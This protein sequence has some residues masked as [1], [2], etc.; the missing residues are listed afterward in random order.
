MSDWQLMRQSLEDEGRWLARLRL[1]GELRCRILFKRCVCLG[2]LS[3]MFV[4]SWDWHE[5]SKLL[6]GPT[7]QALVYLF[8]IT[9]MLLAYNLSIQMFSKPK[10]SISEV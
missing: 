1:E 4:S 8:N 5:R 6:A 9:L 2:S 10:Y 3:F 7:S